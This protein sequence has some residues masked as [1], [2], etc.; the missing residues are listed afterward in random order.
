[1][2]RLIVLL[3]RDR[4]G[5]TGV[6]VAALLP[7]LIG[8]AAFAVDLGA[9]GLDARRLQGIA[10]GAAIAA[11][12]NPANAQ[13]LADATVTAAGFR[14]VI[15]VAVTPGRFDA[16]RPLGDRFVADAAAPQAV[17]VSLSTQS[18]TFFARIFGIGS[19]A[20][21]RSATASQT[22]LAAFSIGSWLASVQGGVLNA[23]LGA[24]TGSTVSLSVMDYNTLAG[25]QIDLLDYIDA[26][27]ATAGLKAG[28]FDDTLDAQVTTP[29]LLDALAD[30]LP[31]SAGAQASAIHGIAAH[32][33]PTTASLSSLIDLGAIGR[34]SGGGRGVAKVDALTL[35]S[36]LAQIANGNRQVQLDL[37]ASIAGLAQTRIWLAIGQR[38]QNSPWLTVTA[39]GTPIIRT[40]QMRLYV[41]ASLAN[42]SLPGLGSLVALKVPLY[43][44]LASAEAKLNAIDCSAD[45]AV[46]IDARPSPGQAAIATID[47]ARLN[48]FSRPVPQSTA[49]I[50]DTLLLDVD[51]QATI[52]LGAAQPWQPVRFTQD[53]I[54][55][56]TTRTVSGGT[57]A[58]GIAASLMSKIALTVRLI[59]LPINLSPLLQAL[60]QQLTLLAP[61]LD[62]LIDTV[63]GLVGLHLGQAD[64][65]ATG[66]RCGMPSLVA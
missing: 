24:L 15:T 6:L 56:G 32:A 33:G 45:R 23:L 48:D 50:L 43:V 3:L 47:P 63:T 4:G 49:T 34:Q 11:A 25:T 60:G 8:M 38:P 66:V 36:M 61:L 12:T 65:R 20:I 51:A 17:R 10:D 13:A 27:H 35:L 53:D 18:P 28:T 21:R 14:R 64:V 59:G 46:T 26:L 52:D 31:A 55:R 40:A 58:Q 62:G 44:E 42:V 29:Q 2:T 54:D 1:M 39:S 22:N 7:F 41:E 16:S 30:A 37:G 5:G 19:M 9:A 57:L